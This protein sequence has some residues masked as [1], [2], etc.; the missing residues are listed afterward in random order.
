[1]ADPTRF[2]TLDEVLRV[3]KDLKRRKKRSVLSFSNLIVFR[4]AACCGLR[5]GEIAG[6]KC[7][8]L[9]LAGVRPCILIRKEN[10]KHQNGKSRS[11]KIPLWWDAGTCQDLQAW[12][13]YREEMQ[14]MASDPVIC[15][16]SK[17]NRGQPLT[18]GLL[19]RR[20]K[21]AIRS[22]GPARVH[23][24]SIHTGRHSFASLSFEAGHSLVEVKEALGHASVSTTSLYLHAV[25]RDVPDV[26]AA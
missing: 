1:M 20:W 14:A 9:V 13:G 23:Q 21:T 19:A 10:T 6:L 18:G 8:D 3:I 5:R 12:I 7:T 24:L 2:L 11:R 15:G 25:S 17:V 22:L 4:L 16:V 26:F